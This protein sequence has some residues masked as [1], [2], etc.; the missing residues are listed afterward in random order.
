MEPGKPTHGRADCVV[1]TSPEMFRK[2]VNESYVP[3]MDEFMNG[4]IKTNDVGL[5]MAFQNIFAL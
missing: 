1:K 5:L 2:M 3:S 4:H